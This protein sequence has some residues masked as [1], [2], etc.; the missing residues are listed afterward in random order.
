MSSIQYGMMTKIRVFYDVVLWI[1][2]FEHSIILKCTISTTMNILNFIV[3]VFIKVYNVSRFFYFA[4]ISNNLCNIAIVHFQS[5]PPI[6][7]AMQTSRPAMNVWYQRTGPG[8]T[9]LFGFIC[10]S[11]FF[12]FSWSPR[13]FKVVRISGFYNSTDK[14]VVLIKCCAAGFMLL[15]SPLSNTLWWKSPQTSTLRGTKQ[16]IPSENP[17]LIVL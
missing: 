2:Y 4:V 11:A 5:S 14:G 1:I 17:I 7:S 15:P 9:E 3:C 13:F 10:S 12:W 8:A 16:F 6:Y